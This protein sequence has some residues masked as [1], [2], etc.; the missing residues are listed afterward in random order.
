MENKS[1]FSLRG[2]ICAVLLFPVLGLSIPTA[3]GLWFTHTGSA[4][5]AQ[6]VV[7]TGNAPVALEVTGETYVG[8]YIEVPLSATDADGDAVVYKLVDDP[9]LGS[10]SIDGGTLKYTPKDDT[11]G[12]DK[13]TYSAIDTTGN[14]S[15]PAQIKI[16]IRKNAAKMTYSDMQNNPVHY[17][18]LC[19]AQDGVMTGEK[20][21]NSYFLHPTAA[22]SRSEF[23]AMASAVAHLPIKQTAQ[24]DFIDDD[25][26]S[27]WAK[28]YI[29][30]AASSGLI[31]GYVTTA[32][33]SELRGE[34]PITA[35]E[36]C[37]I[38]SNLLTENFDAPAEVST[39]KD[40]STPAWAATATARLEA[41]HILPTEPSNTKITREMACKMLYDASLLMDS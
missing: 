6:T 41:A 34:K 31:S 26:I 29:S 39:M 37:V 32:G 38:V 28:P 27:S 3:F 7:A 36:A 33:T 2:L 5:A 14:T 18:A 8:V 16:K 12:T 24:T 19:L 25:G 13:F 9:R 15:E 20:I 22:V 11:T 40:G 17:A 21:G 23:I 30:A 10:A 35:A 1:K 4:D